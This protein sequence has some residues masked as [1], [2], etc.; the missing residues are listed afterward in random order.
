MS[1]IDYL[2][3]C[4]PQTINKRGSRTWNVRARFDALVL[5]VTLLNCVHNLG[6]VRRGAGREPIGGGLRTYVRVP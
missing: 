3:T 6:T 5:M 4:A 1:V 2:S